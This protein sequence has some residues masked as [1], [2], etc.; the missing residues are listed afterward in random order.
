MF[1]LLFLLSWDL[2]IKK[3]RSEKNSTCDRSREYLL[4]LMEHHK[5]NFAFMANESFS[6]A[7]EG[8]GGFLGLKATV[9]NVFNSPKVRFFASG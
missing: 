5:A 7:F 8:E 1:F 9:K 4:D 2:I 6:Y 3:L